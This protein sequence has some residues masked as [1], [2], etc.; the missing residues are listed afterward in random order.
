MT[1]RA[2][3]NDHGRRELKI[4]L[5]GFMVILWDLRR[6]VGASLGCSPGVD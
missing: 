4:D 3:A 2:V 5:S 6:G 1:Y